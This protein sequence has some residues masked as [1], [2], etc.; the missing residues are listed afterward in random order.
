MS[1]GYISLK[2][3]KDDKIV[4]KTD[5]CNERFGT[6]ESKP[7]APLGIDEVLGAMQSFMAGRKAQ[8]CRVVKFLVLAGK[9]VVGVRETVTVAHDVGVHPALS[10]LEHH[11]IP[12]HIRECGH[13]LAGA[14]VKEDRSFGVEF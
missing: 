8:N 7:Q 4:P 9:E 3:T 13:F 6:L 11:L 1:N 2:I 14:T 10:G 12:E 5:L